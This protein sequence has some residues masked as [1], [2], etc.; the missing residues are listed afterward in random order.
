MCMIS[1]VVRPYYKAEQMIATECSTVSVTRG[2]GTLICSCGR[3]CIDACEVRCTFVQ[4]RYNTPFNGSRRIGKLS[5]QEYEL[6]GEVNLL[7]VVT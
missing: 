1:F 6:N 4:V 5:Y 2:V 3:R 7:S